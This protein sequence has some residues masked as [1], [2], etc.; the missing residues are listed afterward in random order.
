MV[1]GRGGS[2]RDSENHVEDNL[3]EVQ[4]HACIG[5]LTPFYL[6]IASKVISGWIWQANWQS[7]CG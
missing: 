3:S 5:L 4:Y 1:L 7:D 2:G 6:E